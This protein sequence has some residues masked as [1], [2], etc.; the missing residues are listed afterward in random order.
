MIEKLRK[1]G[2][3]I[4]G[5]VPWGTHFCQFYQTREELVGILAPYVKAGLENN[6]FCMWVTSVLLA[7]QEAKEALQKV[8]PDI[9]RYL[10][11]G[12]LEIIAHTDWYIKE[13]SFDSQRTSSGWIE[14]LDHA[15]ANGYD[16]LRL[17]GNT[18]RLKKDDWK[19]FAAHEKEIDGIICKNRMIALCTYSLDNGNAAEVIDVVNNHQFALT[20]REGKW[21]L[22]ENSK[23]RRAGYEIEHLA[24]FP[25]L[26]PNPVIEVDS[27][28]TVTFANEATYNLLKQLGVGK[29]VHILMP[30]DLDEMIKSMGHGKESRSFYREVEVKDHIFAEAIHISDEPP[31]ARIY[32]HDITERKRA[33]EELRS[34]EARYRSL[35]ESSPDGVIVHRRGKFLYANSVALKLYGAETLEQLQEKTVLELI[36]PDERAVIESRMRQGLAGQRL[37]LQETRML[38]L[39]GRVTYIESVGGMIDFQGEPAVQIIIRDI[40]GSKRRE[41]ELSRINRT[42]RA[43]SNSNQAMMHATAEPEYLQEVCRVVVEDCGHAMVWIGYAEEDAGKTVQVVAHAGFDEGYLEKL[44]I[45]WA[46][47]EHGRGPTGTA[48]RTGKVSMCRNM[49][50]DPLFMPWREEARKRGYASSIVLPLMEG[51]KAFGA[52]SIYSR[53]PDPFSEDEVKLLTELACDLAYGITAIRL[54][55]AHAKAEEALRMARDE[56][57]LRVQERTGELVKAIQALEAEITER[58]RTENILSVK[59][60]EL[61]TFFKHSSSCMVFLDRGFNFIRVN[62]AYAKVCHRDVSEFPGH[63]HFEYY[64]SDEL[65]DKFERVVET[66]E[67]YNVFARPFVFHDHPEWGVSYWDLSLYPV[68]DDAGEIAFLVYVLNDVTERKLSEENLR[69]SEERFRT[70]VETMLDGFAIFSAVRDDAGRIIDFRYE[71]VNEAVCQ[72]N[73]QTREEM[74]G[75]SLLELRPAY[76]DMGLFDEYIRLTETGRPIIKESWVREDI[77]G[78]GEQHKQAFDFRAVKLG[79]GIAIAVR[80]V[81]DRKRSEEAIQQSAA[82]IHDLYNSAP[83][84]YHSL[85]KDGVFV[86]INDTELKWLGYTREEILRKMKFLDILTPK[87]LHTFMDNFSRFK[88]QGWINNLEFE[89]KRKDG[90]I[91]PVLLNATAIKD[92]EGNYVLSRSTLF[93]ITERKKASEALRMA[94]AYNRSLIEASVDPFVTIGPDGKITDVNHATEKFTG[95]TRKELVGTDFSDY[96]TE[97]DRA[98]SGYREVFEKGEVRDFGLDLKHRDGSVFNVMYNASLYRDE[99]GN[100]LGVFAVARDITERMKL[101]EEIRKAARDWQ[102]TF[103]SIKDHVMILDEDFKIYR[104]NAATASFL[105][106]P[107]DKI[108]NNHCFSLMHGTGGPI[109]G[110]PLAKTLKTKRHEEVEHHDETRDRWFLASVDPVVNNKGEIIRVIHTVKDITERKRAEEEKKRL[111]IQLI[112]AQKIEAL[113][114]LAGGIA[115]DF[116]NVLQPILINSE[117]IS[118]TLLIGTQEREYLDQIIEAAQ[119]GKNLVKQIKLFGTTKK[120]FSKPIAVGPVIKDALAF[121]KQSLPPHVK[122]KQSITTQRNLVYAEP[123]QIYQLILNLCTNALQAIKSDKGSLSV[124]LKEAKIAKTAQAFVDDLTPGRYVKLTVRDT[125]CGISREIKDKIFDPFFTT[126]MSGKGTGLGLAVVHEVVKNAGGSILLHSE[127]GKGATFEIFFPLHL[128]SGNQTLI[129]SPIMNRHNE[130]HILLVDDNSVELHSIHQLLVHIG[131]RVTATTDPQEALSLFMSEPDKF[132]LLITDQVMPWMKGHEL[133]TRVHEIR[134]DFPVIVCSGSEAALQELQEQRVDIH[135]YILKPFSRSELADAIERILS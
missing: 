84:G 81:T 55:M 70:S 78:R 83:C 86:R 125:G 46:D 1:T 99:A 15:L 3:D 87:S 130:K 76:K 47:T 19:G 88:E 64:P 37:P 94:N 80:D 74:I 50:T 12:Q 17:T 71:Y 119:L 131:H 42:L 32:V 13:G 35:V 75:H 103:D 53:E 118:D 135:E 33:E 82:E 96:F 43:L 77:F 57:E 113:G 93:D 54:R 126:R 108:T 109:D 98:R 116:N 28:G 38:N 134:E 115:H 123:T 97:P 133:A 89:M 101:D 67:P 7:G 27:Y 41:E 69:K 100:P 14:K 62:D 5:D 30:G 40:T 51:S 124:T 23:C 48:I 114:K 122:F 34:S 2:I 110:C 63:N 52:I 129:S 58:M 132:S 104:V 92:N 29:D 66:K 60:R 65:K 90:T 73:K 31:L 9:D 79:D 6:E 45:T 107:L 11:R 72:I 128:D 39:D 26:N 120:S 8:I 85:D 91:M 61:E 24:S 106:L 25:R 56:L 36:H 111:E 16:G 112:Q 22:L 49:L 21:E 4:V 44:D 121:F 105:N 117:L 102:V 20:I 95:R 59:T 68:F 127:V 18:F 10:E